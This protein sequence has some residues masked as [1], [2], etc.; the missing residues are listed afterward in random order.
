MSGLDWF[1]FP[2]QIIPFWKDAHLAEFD[3]NKFLEI[4]GKRFCEI[5]SKS[6]DWFQWF[7]VYFVAQ[8]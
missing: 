2:M 4:M 8:I 7:L 6:I 3:V 1:L 5:D